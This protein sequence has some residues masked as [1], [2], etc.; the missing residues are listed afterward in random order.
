MF[1][2]LKQGTLNSG[3]PFFK[4]GTPPHRDAPF[5]TGFLGFERF[6]VLGRGLRLLQGSFGKLQFYPASFFLQQVLF[7]ERFSP[8]EMFFFERFTKTYFF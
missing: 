5:L 4:G 8:Q 6:G 2:C 1:G 7:F 3:E